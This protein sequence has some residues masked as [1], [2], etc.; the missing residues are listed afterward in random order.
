M[1]SILKNN[2]FSISFGTGLSKLAGCVRQI[3]IAAAFGVGITYDAFNYA[4]II[5]GFLLIIIGGI[6]GPLHN[7]VVAVLTP[8]SKKDGAI[9]LTK[10]SIKLSILLLGLAVFIY[11]NSSLLIE[12]L[13]PNLSYE[14]KSIATYQLKILTPCIPL[15]GFI[16][17]SF[18]ALNSRRKFFLSSISPAITSVTTIFFIVFSWILNHEN[19]SSNFLTYTGLLAFATL[20]GTFIQFV[21][22]IWE[23]NKIGLFKLESNFKLFKDEERRIFKLIIPA[24]ISS[25]LSQINVFID[26][27]FASSFQGAASGLAYGNFL[28]QAPLGILSNSI[29]LPLL[30]KF[31]QLRSC[32]DNRGF[33]KNLISGIEYCF[34]TTIFLT[35]F[36]IT[37]NNQIVQ[38]VFQ[39]GAF[40]YS[41][42]LKVKNILIA[43]AFGI[44]FYLYRD[45]L[46]RT[47][48]SIEKTKFP[49]K[50]SFAGIIFNIFF[51]WFLIGAPIKNLGDLSPYNFGVVGI[52]FSSVIVNFII[53]ILL[54]FN[55]QN[56]EIHLPKLNL[57]KKITLMSLAS[58]IDSK[59]CFNILK[60]T[61]NLNSIFGEILLLI[62]GS[63]TFFVIYFFLTKFL[64]VNKFKIYK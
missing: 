64:N 35:G 27:F 37:F 7:A 5:P 22:Q 52:I 30:P 55:L 59:L 8:L 48:Y 46:V 29:I 10:V 6:N 3:F 32:R 14:A 49:F 9:I 31:S 13:A 15:S 23:I 44:P 36:F 42:T 47:Y 58:F 24:S 2:I 17:L 41:A 20:V 38:L 16:G 18:G 43:Y 1:H 21:V 39:R 33:Q 61:N 12:L 51:D 26:M 57:L 25:G 53:C 4:Y 19:T 56:E 63:L 28:V 50:L 60:T 45:L 34:L 11:F 62:F 54:S 40:D